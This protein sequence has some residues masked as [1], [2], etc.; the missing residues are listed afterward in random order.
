MSDSEKPRINPMAILREE[1]DDWAVVFDPDTGKAFG[2]NPTGVI[3]WKC[4]DGAHTIG[5]IAQI[6]RD[7][8]EDA[9]ENIV[10]DLEEFVS[11]LVEQGLAG[12]EAD[13]TAGKTD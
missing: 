10:A 2:L 4:L 6:V 9:P 1:F 3:I 12:Y 7:R 5:Q 13:W 8:V 11:V